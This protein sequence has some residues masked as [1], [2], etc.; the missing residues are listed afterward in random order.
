MHSSAHGRRVLI[1]A[2]V[3]LTPLI[4]L[5]G[6][7]AQTPPVDRGSEKSAVAQI[8][9]DY[10]AAFSEG[11]PKKVAPYYDVP[12]ALVFPMA[13]RSLATAAEIEKWLGTIRADMR[14]RG[15]ENVIIDELNVKILGKDIALLSS[16]YRR[17]AKDGKTLERGASTYFLRKTDGGWKISAVTAHPPEDTVKLD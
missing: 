1:A 13:A 16:N 12:V 9:R 4:A 6:A 11:D 2:L 8:F 15:V 17:L 7:F 14:N 10:I 5:P 3:A